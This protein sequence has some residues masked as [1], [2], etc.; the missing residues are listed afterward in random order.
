M[1]IRYCSFRAIRIIAITLA[2]LCAANTLIA[3]TMPILTYMK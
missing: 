1:K 3:Q 2:I